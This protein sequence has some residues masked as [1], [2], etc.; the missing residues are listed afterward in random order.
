MA[1]FITFNPTVQAILDKVD[2]IAA[3]NS[4]VL[5]LGESGTGKELIAQRIHEKSAR[6]HK[7]FVC[8][9]CGALQESL[10][11]S[12]LFGYEKGAFTGASQP[13]KGLVEKADQGTLFLDEIGELSIE[14]QVKLLRFLQGGEV[15]RLGSEQEVKVN[16]RVLSA[17]HQN[18]WQKVEK[19]TFRQDLLYRINTI[20]FSIPPLRTRNEDIPHLLEYFLNREEE[21]KYVLSERALNHLKKY[22]WPGNVRELENLTQR[23]KILAD[24][25]RITEADLPMEYL[26]GANTAQTDTAWKPEQS[27]L[28]SE[29]EKHHILRVLSHFKGN[30]TRAAEAMG[31][32]VKT[33]Y[34]KLNEYGDS[35]LVT[36]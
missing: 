21:K 32:T 30:K 9:N 7:P 31:I 23:L 35:P 3:S 1:S 33:L 6:S 25:H 11:V 22:P 27:L 17:T 19:G 13:K 36:H 29:I 20:S 16:V 24:S 2:R 5:I 10:L 18:L 26:G 34:N 4:S 12:E 8:V 15:Q 14:A 28:L